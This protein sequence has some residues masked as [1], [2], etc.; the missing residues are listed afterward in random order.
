[1]V[2]KL[3]TADEYLLLCRSQIQIRS[4]LVFTGRVRT[5]LYCGF[6]DFVCWIFPKALSSQLVT[7]WIMWWCFEKWQRPL[8]TYVMS[9]NSHVIITRTTVPLDHSIAKLKRFWD[10]LFWA[11]GGVL[12]TLLHYITMRGLQILT[13]NCKSICP[14]A[15][16][17]WSTVA[18]LALP[19]L[20]PHVTR[21]L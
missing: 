19:P 6:H 18:A 16:I 5:S 14:I 7:R 13:A 12:K 11:A 2:R 8:V 20:G 9:M 4:I 15:T 10:N 17:S 3:A 1:M 21:Y